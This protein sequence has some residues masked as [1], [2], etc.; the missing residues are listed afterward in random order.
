MLWESEA[1]F[2]FMRRARSSL[3]SR[4]GNSPKP[5]N[6]QGT[7]PASRS[8]TAEALKGRLMSSRNIERREAIKGA[9]PTSKLPRSEEHTSE[10]QSRLHLECRLLL[11]KKKHALNHLRAD[12]RIKPCKRVVEDG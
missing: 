3:W 9:L 1:C 7:K 11:E 12:E 8:R 6:S 4:V 10:L 2:C 5:A